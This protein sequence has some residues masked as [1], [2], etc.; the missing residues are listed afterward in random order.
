[1]IKGMDKSNFKVRQ[2]LSS[3]ASYLLVTFLQS[4]IPKK[5]SSSVPAPPTYPTIDEA[6]SILYNAFNKYSSREILTGIIECYASFYQKM[7]IQW[8]ED[9]Y[10]LILNHTLSL[11]KNTKS[12]QNSSLIVSEYCKYLLRNVIGKILSESAQNNA[13]KI[14]I[15]EHIKKVLA[16]KTFTEEKDLEMKCILDELAALL[17]D[18]GPALIYVPVS[19][20]IYIKNNIKN[21]LQIVIM[22]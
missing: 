7:G 22:I 4:P 9:N 2:S 21:I 17:L 5:K 6:L 18:L 3:A 11:L 12:D 10:S 16:N 15:N 13:V 20:C 19:L 1:M 14:I 8:I